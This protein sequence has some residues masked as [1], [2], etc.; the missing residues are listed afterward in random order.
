MAAI[1]SRINLKKKQWQ[2]RKKKTLFA[3]PD[4]VGD[5]ESVIELN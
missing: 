1:G 2:K 5:I 4:A 3:Q